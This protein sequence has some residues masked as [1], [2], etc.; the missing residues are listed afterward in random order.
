VTT[1]W[2]TNGGEV[3][4]ALSAER[5]AAGAVAFG[6]V[7]TLVVVV[8]E[9]HAKEAMGVAAEGAAAHPCRLLV[10][11]RRA[12]DAAEPRL[13]AEVSVGGGLGTG[14]SVVLRMQGP[15]ASHAESVVLPLLAPDAPVVTWWYGAPPDRVGDDCLGALADRRITDSAA[16]PDPVAALQQRAADYTPGDTDLA[17]TRITH[18]RSLLAATFDSVSGTPTG[19]EVSAEPGNPSAELLAG[20]LAARLGVTV[21]VETS[22]GP[23]LTGVALR[24]DGGNGGG[25]VRLDRPDGRT[26]RL[27]RSDQPDRIL[28][29]PRRQ[30]GDLIG[31]ELRRLDP[32]EP[33]AD[34]LAT[35]AGRPTTE[36]AGTADRPRRRPTAIE[37]QGEGAAGRR[38]GSGAAT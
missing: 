35:A 23:G 4:K 28:P 36:G 26:A 12:P 14:E 18:W 19:A 17:W 16:A 15:L 3:V 5:R 21:P 24:F 10:V 38:L 11:V 20:W 32:D 37:R 31:E 25:T 27:A 34:A 30:L 7:L 2:D 8:D 29:L 6:L 33:Y 9:R 22:A 1:L 13:D